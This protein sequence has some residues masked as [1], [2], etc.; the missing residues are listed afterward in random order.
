MSVLLFVLPRESDWVL[1][2]T[3]AKDGGRGEL[4]IAYSAALKS[5]GL[6]RTAE[7]IPSLTYIRLC[8]RIFML[9]IAESDDFS[10]V[11]PKYWTAEEF[12]DFCAWLALNPDAGDVIPR[13]GGVRKV[14]W[15]I[16][17]RGKRGGV[18]VIYFNRLPEGKV[19]LLTMY[20][21]AV[22]KDIEAK[23]VK[24]LRESI[25]E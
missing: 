3:L 22:Q 20:A 21:K 10:E 1:S 5:A 7:S 25:H 17:G 23:L 24:K 18:R 19:W 12:G 4:R 9:T 2:S 15:S 8:R 13:S 6:R 14:R 16:A 11:W